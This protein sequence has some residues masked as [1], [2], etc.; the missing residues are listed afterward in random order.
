MDPL[1]QQV[2]DKYRPVLYELEAIN[3]IRQCQR[4]WEENYQDNDPL[5]IAEYVND[6]ED[7]GEV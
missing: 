4:E 2:L 3:F 7:E 6:S 1:I 5:G